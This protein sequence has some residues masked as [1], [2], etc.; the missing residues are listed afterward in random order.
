M[1]FYIL[2]LFLRGSARTANFAIQSKLKFEAQ[3]Y[4]ESARAARLAGYSYKSYLGKSTIKSDSRD[5]LCSRAAM[6]VQ[7]INKHLYALLYFKSIFEGVGKDG[8][9]CFSI[10]TACNLKH[11]VSWSQQE[12]Q[13]WQEMQSNYILTSLQ[14]QILVEC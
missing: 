13:D 9:L 10:I 14:G 6:S 7:S 8:E 1:H 4:M 12:R 11:Q 5:G 3:N 2:S